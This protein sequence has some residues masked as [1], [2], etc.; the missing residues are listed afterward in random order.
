MAVWP[1]DFTGAGC[2]RQIADKFVY[3]PFISTL[4]VRQQYNARVSVVQISAVVIC[5]T[6][7]CGNLAT[8]HKVIA[9]SDPG[10]GVYEGR[11]LCS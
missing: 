8:K 2:H 1:Y 7:S 11:F 4:K 6:N 3:K 9:P 10:C 5:F